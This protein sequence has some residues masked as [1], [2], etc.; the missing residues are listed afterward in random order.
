M[1]S[2]A[3]ASLEYRMKGSGDPTLYFITSKLLLFFSYKIYLLKK[4]KLSEVTTTM[5]SNTYFDYKNCAVCAEAN[6]WLS[7]L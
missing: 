4:K 5:I 3:S 7:A 6:D 1:T 2:T